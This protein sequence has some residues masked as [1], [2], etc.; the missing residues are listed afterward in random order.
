KYSPRPG[1]TA[2]DRLPDDVPEEVKKA[3]NNE[4]LRIQA[5]VSTQVHAAQIGR[6]VRVFVESISSKARKSRNAA[7]PSVTLGWEKPQEIT[8]LSGRTDGDLIVMFEGDPS[9]VGQ[10]VEIEI[11]SAGSLALFGRLV[12]QDQAV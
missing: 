1:T 12:E 10:I 5:E 2:H 8:Q 9:L 6:Q 3:R 7:D 4:L 11:V